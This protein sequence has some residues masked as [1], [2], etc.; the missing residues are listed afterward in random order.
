MTNESLMKAPNPDFLVPITKAK[1]LKQRCL[2]A[3][4]ELET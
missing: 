1:T 2:R 4:P 3:F